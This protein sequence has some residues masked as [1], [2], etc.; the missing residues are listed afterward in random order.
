MYA[1]PYIFRSN[2][3]CTAALLVCM[4][5]WGMGLALGDIDGE[6]CPDITPPVMVRYGNILGVTSN[7]K[8][9]VQLIQVILC[10]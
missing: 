4:T 3:A 2:A 7:Q 1:H 9:H 8:Q 5:A 6:I 10:A